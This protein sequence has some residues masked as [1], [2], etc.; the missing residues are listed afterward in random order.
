VL[1][2]DTNVSEDH[3][4]S[5]FNLKTEAAWSSMKPHSYPC[6]VAECDG[7]I[8]EFYS[9]RSESFCLSTLSNSSVHLA[10]EAAPPVPVHR[11]LSVLSSVRTLRWVRTDVPCFLIECD[12]KASPLRLCFISYVDYT[13]AL[14]DLF[15]EAMACDIFR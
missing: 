15:P 10:C 1:L 2:Y 5:F 3:T 13:F 14:W 9:N 11:Q 8:S 4:A 7:Q 6:A 12:L